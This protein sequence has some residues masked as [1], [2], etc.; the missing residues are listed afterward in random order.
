MI[1]FHHLIALAVL[2]L[3]L[4]VFSIA[5]PTE[6]DSGSENICRFPL[7]RKEWLGY[8]LEFS[9]DVTLNNGW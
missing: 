6:D 7:R 5:L 2:A 9:N 8:L 3:G 1:R 4:R